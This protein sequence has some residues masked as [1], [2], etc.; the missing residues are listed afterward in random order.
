VRVLLNG[1]E[2][3]TGLMPPLGT[4]LNDAD[5][6]AVLTYIRR[7][8]GQAASP[9]EPDLV[10]GV[11]ALTANRP[12]PWTSDELLSLAPAAPGGPQ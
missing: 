10:A 4:M 2:G 11:R 7:E 1:K 3:A 9:I 6:A 12:R 5:V 8:W